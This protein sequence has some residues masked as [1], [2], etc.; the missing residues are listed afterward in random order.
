M[1]SMG[2]KVHGDRLVVF[3][4]AL[5]APLAADEADVAQARGGLRQQG[6]EFRFSSRVHDATTAHEVGVAHFW[7]PPRSIR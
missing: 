2:S 7:V 1:S 4:A 6:V 3:V 5:L